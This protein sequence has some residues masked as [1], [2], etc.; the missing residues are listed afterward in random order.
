MRGL[1]RLL[2]RYPA[3]P[4][5]LA[6]TWRQPLQSAYIGAGHPLLAVEAELDA[7]LGRRH[8]S[9]FGLDLRFPYRDVEV[10]RFMASLPAHFSVRDGARKWI[11]R[12][13][14]RD[15]L[16]ERVRTRAKAGS[17]EPFFRKA[18]LGDANALVQRLLRDP[19]A[20]WPRYVMPEQLWAA[21][22]QPATEAEL[23]LIWLAVS[24]ELWWRAHAGLG[25]A[26]L[27]SEP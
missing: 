8:S 3:L 10:I 18:I 12:E 11:T 5:W 27:A 26:V 9:S 23:L 14:M 16:P 1:R 22:A 25:P 4:H 24:Y 17:L 13:A 20:K 19:G 7:E 21:V 15:R 2:G 6:E